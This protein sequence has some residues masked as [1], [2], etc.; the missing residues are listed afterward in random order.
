MK[1]NI[2]YQSSLTSKEIED[3]FKPK[4][5]NHF[6]YQKYC[7]GEDEIPLKAVNGHNGGRP[8]LTKDGK[9][10]RSGNSTWGN[11]KIDSISSKYDIKHS[12]VILPTKKMS[13]R[14]SNQ[15]EIIQIPMSRIDFCVKFGHYKTAII[16]GTIEDDD[17]FYWAGTLHEIK[18]HIKVHYLDTPRN[19][20]HVCS[21]TTYE[22][23]K[24]NKTKKRSNI[25]E[26]YRNLKFHQKVSEI[27][28]LKGFKLIPE[29]KL[30]ASFDNNELEMTRADIVGLK[31]DIISVIV[32]IESTPTPKI[33]CGDIL[34]TSL[35]SFAIRGHKRYLFNKPYLF[36]LLS[37]EIRSRRYSNSDLLN[38][39]D[40]KNIKGNQLTGVQITNIKEIETSLKDFNI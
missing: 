15:K 16:D 36:V 39:I 2:A 12:D 17:F 38:K 11:L 40:I 14:H 28:K 10:M 9:I 26:V 27:L 30:F 25:D 34:A 32:E 33:V 35:C 21:K 8:F 7:M 24:K 19:E 22:N 29:C 23:F 1:N 13:N 31:N 20:F 5:K 37:D 6:W 3:L 18:N 4:T